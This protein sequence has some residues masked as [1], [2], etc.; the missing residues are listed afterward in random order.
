MFRNEKNLLTLKLSVEYILRQVDIRAVPFP[1][2]I[3]ACS[4]G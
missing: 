1:E 3:P 4:E 2:V